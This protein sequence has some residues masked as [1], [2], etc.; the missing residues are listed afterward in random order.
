MVWFSGGISKISERDDNEIAHCLISS[1]FATYHFD[2][3]FFLR[4]SCE[5]T[6]CLLYFVLSLFEENQFSG[7]GS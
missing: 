6:V 7:R 3:E 5:I 2:K 4:T 1:P